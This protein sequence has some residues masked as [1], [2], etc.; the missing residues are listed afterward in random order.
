MKAWPWLLISLS[1]LA[2]CKQNS[3]QHTVPALMIEA[4][5]AALQELQM[6]VAEALGGGNVLLADDVFTQRSELVVERRP[7]SDPQ[8]NRLPGRIIAE[9]EQFRLAL[10]DDRCILLHINSDRQWILT[11]ARCVAANDSHSSSR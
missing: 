7:K 8:G 5:P 1:V 9:P 6:R 11:H 4:T 10:R 3:L 2:A